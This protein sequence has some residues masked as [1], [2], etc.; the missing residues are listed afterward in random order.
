ML[1]NFLTVSD[2]D[3]RAKLWNWLS[4]CK[5]VIRGNLR[6]YKPTRNVVY[7]VMDALKAVANQPSTLAAPCWL[8]EGPKQVIAFANGLLAVDRLMADDSAPL[9]SHT[10]QWFSSNCLPH[11]YDSSAQCPQW[12]AFLKQVFDND[13]ERISALQQWFGYNL[14]ADTD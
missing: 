13:P 4:G 6:N 3:I 1:S 14:I 2:N 5:V 11:P 7:A 9:L 10:P 8:T 12:L